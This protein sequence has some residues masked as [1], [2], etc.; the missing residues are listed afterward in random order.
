MPVPQLLLQPELSHSKLRASVASGLAPLSSSGGRSHGTKLL[1]PMPF[2]VCRLSDWLELVASCFGASNPAIYPRGIRI[3][4]SRMCLFDMPQKLKV[5]LDSSG[6]S[7]RILYMICRT[8]TVESCN[9][10]GK[11][12]SGKTVH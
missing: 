3:F 11:T 6:A 8:V 5:Y 10:S 9:I 1:L 2:C 12:V 7:K 4:I